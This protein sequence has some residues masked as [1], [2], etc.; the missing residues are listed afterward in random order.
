MMKVF[1]DSFRNTKI[2]LIAGIDEA[3]R[4]PLAG[5]VVTAAVVFNPDTIIDGVKDSKKLSA[6]KREEL[7]DII[8][9]SALSYHIEIVD[10]NVID[11]INILN[12]TLLG[13]KLSSEKLSHKP[14]LVL[15]DGN[16]VFESEFKVNSIVKGDSKSFSIAAASILAKV[17]RDRLM[18]E[19]SEKYPYYFWEKNKGYPTKAHIEAIRKNGITP[20]HRSTF[21][22]KILNGEQY[23][24]YK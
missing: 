15:V 21:M 23:E 11:E 19:Y 4:G 5:P 3:G 12:A 13:M 6:K 24:L 16:K 8:I 14:D 18:I 20:L 9:D 22:K 7:Y 10:N 17:T 1:D 2:K